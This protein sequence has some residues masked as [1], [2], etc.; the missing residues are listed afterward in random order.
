MEAKLNAITMELFDRQI[1]TCTDRELYLA[2][3]ELTKKELSQKKIISGPR[4]V[5]YIS[6]EF[7]IGRLL[8]NNLI[9]L[10]IKLQIDEII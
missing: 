2:L 8:S 5:Y 6:A 10:V 7:L 9:N 4:K 1:Q 3:L